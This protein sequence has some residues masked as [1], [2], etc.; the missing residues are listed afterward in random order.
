[1]MPED[2]R[3]I[4]MVVMG[5]MTK[6]PDDFFP[7]ANYLIKIQKE[8]ERIKSEAFIMFINYIYAQYTD[9]LDTIEAITKAAYKIMQI[10]EKFIMDKMTEEQINSL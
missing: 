6:R 5:Q 8:A 3:R 1:M 7:A 4:Q 2:K 10:V 9:E